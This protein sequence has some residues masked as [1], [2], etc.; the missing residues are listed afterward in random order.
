MGQQSS[1]SMSAEREQ[2]FCRSAFKPISAPLL[3]R[4]LLA[5]DHRCASTDP[6]FGA[7]RT[8]FLSARFPPSRQFLFYMSRIVSYTL[9]SD[10]SCKKS[11]GVFFFTK[12]IR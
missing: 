4:R 9:P 11:F 8:I 10:A 3:M 1:H 2:P 5:P 12:G 6:I 7:F